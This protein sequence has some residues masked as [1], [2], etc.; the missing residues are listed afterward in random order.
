MTNESIVDYGTTRDGLIQLRRRWEPVGPPRGAVML[1]HGLGEHSGRYER[2]GARLADHGFVVVSI[3]NRGFGATGGQ[4]AFVDRFDRFYDDLED[5]LGQVRQLGLP[6]LLLGHS[7]GGTI[8]VGYCLSGRPL[9]DALALSGPGLDYERD[10][11][12]RRLKAVAPLIRAIAPGFEVRRSTS[13][14]DLATDP[15]VGEAFHA[16]PLTVDF[17][18]VSLG[19]EITN[20]I[21]HIQPRLGDL[22]L[23]IWV[24]HG[25]DDTNV[26]PSASEPFGAMDNATRV[27]YPGL[28]HEIFQ[29]PTGLEIVDDVATWAVSALGLTPA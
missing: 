21:D 26:P 7:L 27:V 24:G 22:S 16:D 15:G 28:R 8:S 19:L 25:G 18:T 29:E 14:D 4:R 3:D 10:P 17:L 23:P 5:Q 1:V 2:I 9:P 13:L 6:T 11:R 12:S 20:E